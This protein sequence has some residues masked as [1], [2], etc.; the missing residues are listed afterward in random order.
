MRAWTVVLC[1][2]ALLA[3]C[4][5]VS[6]DTKREIHAKTPVGSAALSTDRR[7]DW[8]LR[9]V[10]V[11]GSDLV[12]ELQRVTT[13]R[14][15]SKQAYDISGRRIKTIDRDKD[16]RFKFYF[17]GPAWVTEDSG[18]GNYAKTLV[19]STCMS[20]GG[21]LIVAIIDWVTLPFQ[22]IDRSFDER[23]SESK[24]I[25]RDQRKAPETDGA[26]FQ[27]LKQPYPV[28][29][30]QVSIPRE[31]FFYRRHGYPWG[32]VRIAVQDDDGTWVQRHRTMKSIFGSP[33]RF[34]QVAPPRPQP[35]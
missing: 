10:R 19:L 15:L 18:A 20:L 11:D 1:L 23:I 14:R 31:K 5:L 29:G 12:F 28:R 2:P 8:G 34:K 7:L 3:G 4:V 30:G 9:F 16:G 32:Q 17:F 6:I 35:K 27:L 24:E 22:V 13:E 21:G 25:G 26:G 33:E